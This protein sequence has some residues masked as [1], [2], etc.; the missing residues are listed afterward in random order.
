[1]GQEKWIVAVSGG[2][3]SMVL[4]DTLRLRGYELV[5]AH[6]NYKRRTSS[7]RDQEIVQKYAG[8]YG[9]E[10]EKR[11]YRD[12]G[13]HKNFQQSAR[14]FRYDFFKELCTKYEANGV[15]LG[16]HADD[17]LETYLFQKQ[18]EMRSNSVGID[19]YSRYGEM[20]VWR[21]LLK[22]T[23][24][25][26]LEYCQT[27]NI[28]FG[29][30]ESNAD[31]TY[32]RNRIRAEL[33]AISE[34]EKQSLMESMSQRKHDWE[35][36]KQQFEKRVD[37]WG[38]TIPIPQLLS[39]PHPSLVLRRW[40]EKNNIDVTRTTKKYLDEMVKAIESGTA[41]F[42]FNNQSLFASYGEVTVQSHSALNNR[43]SQ[44]EYGDFDVYAFA[45]EGSKIQG[46]TLS[47]NDFP[48]TVRYAKPGD[49]IALRFGRKKVNRFF[50][51]RKIPHHQREKWLVV[52]NCAKDI[53]FV[54]GIGCDEHHYSNNPNLFV[55]ELNVSQ[56]DH[57]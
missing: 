37:T 4:L 25:D 19:E 27:N 2:P 55:I 10:F 51:D 46:L 30:D 40:L 39:Q 22:Y 20:K 7:D 5:V 42:T 41:K 50:I 15:A 21:P 23:K 53:V 18:R 11:D 49:S 36:Q 8:S 34:T 9:I 44:L 3:D 47:D 26:I 52:E 6:V 29:F 28:I 17:D 38:D 43:H 24:K 13:K 1:M 12:D 35:A 33:N 31:T 32:T 14:V 48:I 54:V 57:F 45:S 56:E 16:H